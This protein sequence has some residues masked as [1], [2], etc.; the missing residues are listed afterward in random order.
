MRRSTTFLVAAAA[1][2]VGVVAVGSSVSAR[3]ETSA[4][5]ER[6][7]RVV[8]LGDSYSSGSGIHRNAS[9]YDDHGPAAHSFNRFTRL[10]SSACQRELDETPGPRLATQLDADSV[11]VACAGAVI[12]EIPAQ[13]RAADIPGDG[14]GTLVTMTIG[15]NDLRTVRD[16]NWPDALTRCITSMRCHDSSKNQMANLDQ[17]REDLVATYRSIGERY[18]DIAVRVLAYPRLMQGNGRCDGVTGISGDEADWIDEQVDLLNH[19]IEVAAA[20]ARGITGAD[21][22]FV[23]V[24]DE[25]D[26]HGACRFWQRDRFVNDA[27]FGDSFRRSQLADGTVQEHWTKGPFNVSTASFHP[28]SKGYDA[29]LATL[30][31]S[32]PPDVLPTR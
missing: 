5:S 28:S 31:T 25:F 14:D 10:G 2:T 3:P 8:T 11:F 7:E 16:E 23:D 6:I 32:L 29:Y 18:P 24:T 26:N 4:G 22:R 15:G 30:R 20:R 21:I 13:I 27:V 1:A 17:I 19:Q 12:R 9:S